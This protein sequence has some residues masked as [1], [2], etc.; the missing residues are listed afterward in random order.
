MSSEWSESSQRSSGSGLSH[1]FEDLEQQAEGLHLVER[2]AEV[3]D[4]SRSEYAEVTLA[5]RLHA[6]IGAVVALSVVGVGTVDGTMSRAGEG[7]C[8][9]ETTLS[10]QEWLVPLRAVKRA[11]GLSERAVSAEARSVVSRL[12]LRSALRG[13]ADARTEVVL[14][15]DDG[16]QTRGVVVRVGADFVELTA[17]AAERADRSRPQATDI[18]PLSRLAAVRCT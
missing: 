14:H 3:R 4:R 10:A 6:S 9:L 11:R 15:H 1:L 18:V 12:S 5:A 16:E 7:W 8:L 17:A 2:D 13:L